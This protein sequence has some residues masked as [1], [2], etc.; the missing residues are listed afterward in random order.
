[1][2]GMEDD[3]TKNQLWEVDENRN[4]FLTPM[5]EHTVIDGHVVESNGVRE[6]E[7]LYYSRFPDESP[8]NG[9]DLGMCADITQVTQA[10]KEIKAL[11]HI[12]NWI[13][14]ISPNVAERYKAR[15][16][17][18][19]ALTVEEDGWTEK[20]WGDGIVYTEDSPQYRAHKFLNEYNDHLHINDCIFYFVFCVWILGKDS[21]DKNMSLFL[22]TLEDFYSDDP[23]VSVNAKVKLRIML[24]DTD[25]TNMFNNTGVLLYK[26]WHE[27]N[28]TYNPNTGETGVITGEIWNGSQ[29]V[30]QSSAPGATPVFNGRLSGLWD[31]IVQY[32]PNQV[33][34]IYQTMRNAGLN[35]QGMM[36][37]YQRFHDYWCEVL[38]NVDGLGYANTGNLNMAYGDKYLLSKYFYKY[39]QR[40][41]DSKYG[42][43]NVAPRTTM[44]LS[45]IPTGI[46]LKHATPMYASFSYGANDPVIARSIV[47]DTPAKLPCNAVALSDAACYINDADLVTEIGVYTES[48][49]VTTYHGLEAM[50]NFHFDQAGF[51][52]LVRLRKFIWANTQASPNIA[53]TE[54][55]GVIEFAELKNLQELVMTYCTQWHGTVVIG[56]EII[57]KIDFAGTPI[58]SITIPETD[59]LT[60]LHLPDSLTTLTL[61]NLPNISIFSI[62][63]IEH[64]TTVNIENAGNADAILAQALLDLVGGGGTPALVS[65]KL[66]FPSLS[67]A[68]YWALKNAYHDFEEEYEIDIFVENDTLY[69]EAPN[70]V[71]LNYAN[72]TLDAGVGQGS[73]TIIPTNPESVTPTL[74]V[75]IDTLT[76]SVEY[77]LIYNDSVITPIDGIST[78]PN[79][80]T[81]DVETGEVTSCVGVN[82]IFS[83]RVVVTAGSTTL[84]SI[85][86]PFSVAVRTY[87]T[88]SIDGK[89]YIPVARD[90]IYNSVLSL[91]YT[92]S[93]Q[94]VEWV[95]EGGNGLVSKTQESNTSVTL[96]A[97]IVD[98]TSPV[99]ATLSF[100]VHFKT[101]NVIAQKSITIK[102]FMNLVDMGLPSGTLWATTNIDVT[103]SDGFAV[104]PFQYESSFFSW[105]NTDGH[106]PTS[107]SS[108]SPYTWGTSNDTE[109]YVSSSGAQLTGNIGLSYDAARV[110]CGAPWRM[111]TK[112]E[113]VELFANIDYVEAD[114]ETVID[115]SRTDKRVTVN[116]V[117][118][119]YLRSKINGNL[120][121]FNCSGRGEGSSWS[122][123]GLYGSF[124]SSSLYSAVSGHYLNFDAGGVRPQSGYYRFIGA[125]IRPIQ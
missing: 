124:W 64:L 46:W 71:Y 122:Y 82:D 10:N 35:T 83:V 95:L 20:D 112:E 15:Y 105:G 11:R 102:K 113:F 87:P 68:A 17:H 62:A 100:I 86:I 40:Y 79:G 109:P 31:A 67:N 106:N 23:A 28:D 117:V 51:S 107:N 27:W 42:V 8:V 76:Y 125:A 88:I 81:L 75:I 69:F 104:S 118:G 18:Y 114:G 120:L 30:I 93:I 77:E 60:E 96:H 108:F 2:F 14:S 16:G 29:Y 61:R 80:S 56:S 103:Q 36:D 92:A 54:Q 63:G 24:R 101:C 43:T 49:G 74:G 48:N 25:T 99:T 58:N 22:D 85:E 33:R 98:N 41:M 97:P 5:T 110:N 45:E 70:A 121:F 72:T 53:Q 9:G 55:N 119:I 115:A 19:R 37:M 57:E 44:R 13:V 34:T 7:P 123:R 59:T 38:Y 66:T 50:K 89:E 21:M 39:R 84:Q 1:M 65:G 52:N 6:S 94:S 111:P 73:A 4:F 91:D 32:I 78:T 47:A 90:Y 3:Y 116:D 12:H 26:Y